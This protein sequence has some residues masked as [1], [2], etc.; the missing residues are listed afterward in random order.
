MKAN[1]A[2]IKSILMK[3]YA[4]E[5]KSKLFYKF[6]GKYFEIVEQ[7]TLQNNIEEIIFNT[8]DEI[9]C[10]RTETNT[11]HVNGHEPLKAS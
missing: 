5:R 11:N 10:K 6:N 1:T 2:Y 9:Q 7:D 8:G 3:K 4:S